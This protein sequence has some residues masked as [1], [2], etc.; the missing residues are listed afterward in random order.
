MTTE[1]ST[2]EELGEASLEAHTLLTRL[3]EADALV[4]ELTEVLAAQTAVLHQLGGAVREWIA[5]KDAHRQAI[6]DYF[7]HTEGASARVIRDKLAV[8]ESCAEML[9]FLTASP[10]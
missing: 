1:H 8:E 2:N 10:S 7:H 4:D 9:R 5:A 6:L 3:T